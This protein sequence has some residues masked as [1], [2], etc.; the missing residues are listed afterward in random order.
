[1]VSPSPLVGVFIAAYIRP[2]ELL[3]MVAGFTMAMLVSG[4]G[5]R[6]GAARRLLSIVFFG[7]VLVLSIFLTFHY[8]HAANS[9]LSLQNIQANNSVSGGSGGVTYSTSPAAYPRDVYV[10]LF[11]PLPITAHGASQY[12]DAFENL[13]IVGLILISLRNLRMVPRAAFARAYVMMCLVYS[14]IF[15]YTFAALGNL[16]LITRERT[17]LF[18]FLFVLLAIPRT[19]KGQPPRYEW[20]VTR[21]QRRI[22]RAAARRAARPRRR[23]PVGPARRA[24]AGGPAP[25]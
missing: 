20:E 7:G 24:P 2:N 25:A 15:L 10:V 14:A 16:G 9:T 17:L 19:P 11:D 1:M 12:V 21:R 4:S 13:L 3:L 23:P 5:S 8:L 22:M 6:Q 18:P